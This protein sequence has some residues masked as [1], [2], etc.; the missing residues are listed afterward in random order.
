MTTLGWNE[1]NSLCG[2]HAT[3]GGLTEQ[4]RAY[5]LEAQRLGM[6]VDV[7]HASDEAFFDMLEIANKPIIASHSNSRAVCPSS[8][9]LTDDMFKA[10]CENGGV[11]GINLYTE[12]VGGQKDMDAVCRHVAHFLELDPTGSHIALGGDLDGCESLVAGFEGIQSYP[13]LANCLQTLGLDDTILHNI[14]WNNA[15]GVMEKCCM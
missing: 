3:G 5:F 2:S 11:A 8:R 4:G 10:I 14:F 12:F 7:S 6:I 15:I 1:Q 9:N 13:A